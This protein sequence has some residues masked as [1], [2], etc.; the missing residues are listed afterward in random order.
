MMETASNALLDTTADGICLV[1]VGQRVTY[2]NLGAERLSGYS[3]AEVIGSRCADRALI[4]LDPAGVDLCGAGCL[5]A[6]TVSDRLSREVQ[7][8]L[9]HRQGHVTPVRARVA[10]VEDPAGRTV[11]AMELF[12][13]SLDPELVAERFALL[14]E[15]ALYHAAT[16]LPDRRLMELV[17]AERGAELDRSGFPFGL[18]LFSLDNLPEIAAAHGGEVAGRAQRMVG[19][20]LSDRARDHDVVG[21]AGEGRFLVVIPGGSP[22]E[23]LERATHLRGVVQRVQAQGRRSTAAVRVSVGVARAQPFDTADSLLRRAERRAAAGRHYE[24]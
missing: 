13:T 1:D 9:R 11:G 16:G 18:I 12:S 20:I 21:H 4:H 2:W 17:V 3:R 8:L 22:D 6:R 19:R 5:L 7:V 24:G 10:P 23:L 15:L 14:P